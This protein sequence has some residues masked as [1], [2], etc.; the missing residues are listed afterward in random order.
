MRHYDSFDKN[1]LLPDE[2]ISYAGSYGVSAFLIKQMSFLSFY[3]MD[4]DYIQGVTNRYGKM[5][6]INVKLILVFMQA[7]S[8][9]VTMKVPP[10]DLGTVLG[11]VMHMGENGVGA[12]NYGFEGQIMSFC[13]NFREFMDRSGSK[14]GNLIHVDDEGDTVFPT[15]RATLVLYRFNPY[16]GN[17][18]RGFQKPPF[19][20]FLIWKTWGEFFPE[21]F[22]Y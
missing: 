2:F 19:G 18:E 9:I 16:V 7:C 5:Y 6:N 21:D 4:P 10:V 20:N 17:V 8:G 14:L 12:P 1:D 15:N 11:W 22:N 3:F 13:K